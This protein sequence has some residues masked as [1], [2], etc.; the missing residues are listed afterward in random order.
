MN[1]TIDRFLVLTLLI[2]VW[3]AGYDSGRNAATSPPA[4][5]Q[6]AE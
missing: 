5:I 1:R 4:S 2:C 3:I 6:R